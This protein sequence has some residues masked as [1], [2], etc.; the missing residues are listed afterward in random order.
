MCA[1]GLLPRLNHTGPR[2]FVSRAL[3][4]LAAS[5]TCFT[6]PARQRCIADMLKLPGPLSRTFYKGATPGLVIC[7]YVLFERRASTLLCQLNMEMF[8]C[9]VWWC[10]FV[11][12]VSWL[13]PR[14][15]L[16]AECIHPSP[17]FSA[18]FWSVPVPRLY[19]DN[20][21]IPV[22]LCRKRVVLCYHLNLMENPGKRQVQSPEDY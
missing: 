11:L 2:L 21:R 18:L 7:C 1:S 5:C 3:I 9:L 10:C 13:C 20:C 17:R 4:N 8:V 16:S 19:T 22:M 14:F 6:S 12:S 15:L